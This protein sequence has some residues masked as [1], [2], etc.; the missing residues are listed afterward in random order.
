MTPGTARAGAPVVSVVIP[1]HNCRAFLPAALASVAAQDLKDIEILIIDD[2]SADDTFAYL[3][4]LRRRM[5][6]V[7]PLRGE[8]RGPGAAR[9]A[10][11]AA[12]RAPLIAFLDADDVWLAGKLARQLA[13][14]H[15]HADAAF[16]FCDYLHVD[17][18][19][20]SHGTSFAY[21]THFRRRA[22]AGHLDYQLLDEPHL[23]LLAENVVGTS[24]VVA[25]RDVL[26]RVGG[27][28]EGLRSASD[29]DLWLR[30]SLEG[31]VGCS[32]HVGAHYLMGRAGAVSRAARDRIE[33]EQI[34][35]ARHARHCLGRKGGTK[36][37]RRARA[38]V[39]TCEAEL[40]ESEG[41]HAQSAAA[42]LRALRLDPTI[43]GMR[44][45]A[46]RLSHLPGGPPQR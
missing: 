38:R 23:T 12:A 1:A 22:G 41:R 35:V 19:G 6:N 42:H 26:R 4:D 24:T 27:F 15:G 10:A 18:A 8:G 21:Y 14:H 3:S 46:A 45:L 29:W 32:W 9:N 20:M 28:D 16:S 11:I 44:A 33:A 40:A 7:A 5:P 37:L 39:I 43:R 25:R 13:F 30:L 36:A 17:T 34:I 2:C 31:P